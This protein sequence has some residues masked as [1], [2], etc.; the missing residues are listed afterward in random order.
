MFFKRRNPVYT[1]RFATPADTDAVRRLVEHA[2]RVYLRIP[3][4][5]ALFHL[6]SGLG[7][8]AGEGDRVGGLILT[9][10]Q[11]ITL[12]DAI[13]YIASIVAA[14]V[15]DD[16]QVAPY[17][18]TFLP[19]VE[20][21]V[22]QKGAT[23]LVQIGYAPWLTTV[24]DERGFIQQDWV[25]TYEWYSQPVT[26]RGNPSVAI[27][28]AHLRDLPTLVSLDERIFGPIWR[29][30]PPNF[31]EALAQAFIFTVAEAEGQI[32][33]YQWSDK[34][35]EHGHLTRLAVRPG[36]E[37]GGVGTRLLTEALVAMVNA[38][39]TW[40]TLNTQESNVRSRELY[41]RHGFHP[42]GERVAVLCKDLKT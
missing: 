15:S 42:T 14:A 18:D 31:T 4:E 30:P 12:E 36:W 24:L 23:A 33:G 5:E 1:A 37:G 27:R 9:E 16:W 22:R 8:V 32:V 21:T 40:V 2:R 19:L 13:A 25:V 6:R 11:P 29:K 20:E 10:I 28:S 3:L 17:L 35:G 38:G 7:W 26:I 41:E 39:V 34:V